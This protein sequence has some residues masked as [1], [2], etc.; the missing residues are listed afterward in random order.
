MV[1]MKRSSV[2]PR[3]PRSTAAQRAQ[4]VRRFLRSNLSPSEFALQRGLRLCTL[5]R[6]IRQSSGPAAP[7]V[8]TPAFA[9]LKLPDPLPPARWAAELARPDGLTLR[10]AHDVGASL[11]RQLVRAW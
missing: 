10:L 2:V 5:Q 1:G 6:W 11:I 3:R 9:E 7:P 4:W 8:I